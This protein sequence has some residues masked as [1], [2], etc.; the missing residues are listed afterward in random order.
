M[1]NY[2]AHHG[3]K[4][5][6][7]GVRRTPEEL[8]REDRKARAVAAAISESQYRKLRD[9]RKREGINDVLYNELVNK[10]GAKN[11]RFGLS[12]SE[13]KEGRKTY[14][15]LKLRNQ[16]KELSDILSQAWDSLSFEPGSA[17]RNRLMHLT[18]VVESHTNT[19]GQVKGVGI[20]ASSE[21]ERMKMNSRLN[22]THTDRFGQN[23]D[24]EDEY[25]KIRN[26]QEGRGG[27][28]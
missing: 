2:L 5:Q 28:Y 7:W 20:T 14:E 22:K 15:D 8:G 6:K 24:I 25:A 10:K 1:E 9:Y 11:Y 19:K 27:R 23:W 3:V 16:S 12:K 13:I 18:D 17:E 26:K 21:R 4:G